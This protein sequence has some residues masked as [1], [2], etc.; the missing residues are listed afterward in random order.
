MDTNKSTLTDEIFAR[1]AP[2]LR[3]AGFAVLP[4]HGKQPMR[5]GFSTWRYAP[6][7]SAV[8]KWAKKDPCADIVYVPG[9]SK[10]KRGGNGLIVVDA[11]D[12][13]ACNRVIETFGDTAGKVKTRRGEHFLYRDHG[14]SLGNLSSLKKLGIN[15]DVKHGQNGAGIVCAPPSIHEK[16]PSFAYAWDG[17]DAT[18]IRDLP[19]FPISALQALIDRAGPGSK[20]VPNIT[21]TAP[22]PRPPVR[23]G[24][25][26]ESRGLGLNDALCEQVWAVNTEGELLD[27]AREINLGF[28]VPLDDAEVI[29]RT[30]AVW[31]D[32]VEGILQNW[33]GRK[34]TARPCRDELRMLSALGSNGGDAAM[35][36]MLLRAEHTARVRRGESFAINP[37]AMAER[38]SL[39]W[40]PRR[41]R[42]AR[43]ALLRGGF[44]TVAE[45][46]KNSRNGRVSAQYTLTSAG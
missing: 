5:K 12:A 8:A 13:E 10:A 1:E 46:C 9:L 31:N 19:V 18:V 17:C 26:E 2:A 11:D 15:A 34:A 28:P 39:Q 38:R 20:S 40:T 45:P 32:R 43:D 6:G 44:I 25:R 4:A 37:K 23:D 29:S 7:P 24:F 22:A 27:V 30:H 33:R 36:L 35:L 3:E 14:G 41:F 42:G 16:D 21:T